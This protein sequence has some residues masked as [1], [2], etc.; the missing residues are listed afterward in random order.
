MGRPPTVNHISSETA[1]TLT[2][3]LCLHVDPDCCFAARAVWQ[4]NN[5]LRA[6][7]ESPFNAATSRFS[8]VNIGLKKHQSELVWSAQMTLLVGVPS[9][10]THRA[11]TESPAPGNFQRAYFFSTVFT[12][13]AKYTVW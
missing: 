7:L 4:P 6:P 8:G 13:S 5:R 9:S 2:P 12:S 11:C 3:S 1:T 10:V